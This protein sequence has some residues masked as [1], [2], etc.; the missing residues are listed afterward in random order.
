MSFRWPGDAGYAIMAKGTV[1]HQTRRLQGTAVGKLLPTL[2]RQSD[3]V[4]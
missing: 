2:A 1:L 3:I 4:A